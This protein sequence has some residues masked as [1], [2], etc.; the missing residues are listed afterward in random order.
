MDD[1]NFALPRFRIINFKSIFKLELLGNSVRFDVTPTAFLLFLNH[2][3]HVFGKRIRQDL[4]K[5]FMWKLCG[6]GKVDICMIF[7]MREQII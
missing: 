5:K 2:E 6:W 7:H 1:S 3:D 4:P